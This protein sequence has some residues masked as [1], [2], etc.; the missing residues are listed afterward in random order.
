MH[1]CG[2]VS[3][4]LNSLH[5]ALHNSGIRGFSLVPKQVIE[6]SPD[7]LVATFVVREVLRPHLVITPPKCIAR[8]TVE[9]CFVDSL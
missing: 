5:R 4:K 8:R 6:F 7:N 1:G 9:P 3:I 2:V